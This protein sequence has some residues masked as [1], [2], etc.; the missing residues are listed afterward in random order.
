ML[1]VLICSSIYTSFTQMGPSY[2]FPQHLRDQTTN[3]IMFAQVLVLNFNFH[4][5]KKLKKS[6]QQLKKT[7]S[8][9]RY[10]KNL[11][12]NELQRVEAFVQDPMNCLLAL[13]EMRHIRKLIR[14]WA[15]HND[16]SIASNKLK[17]LQ[18]QIPM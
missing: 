18:S 2:V 13:Q 14:L 9:N 8:F 4:K 3:L 6:W 11:N 10:F 12:E 5:P 7:S 15:R 1:L 17:S 16:S